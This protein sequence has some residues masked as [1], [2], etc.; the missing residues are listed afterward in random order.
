MPVFLNTCERDFETRFAA[1]LLAKREEA[2]D[3]DAAVAR[4]ID[5]V[6]QRASEVLVAL[7]EG[8]L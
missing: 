4:I 8:S 2:P 6:R 7:D 3:V 1:L 5:D